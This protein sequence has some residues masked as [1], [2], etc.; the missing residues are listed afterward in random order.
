MAMRRTPCTGRAGAGAGA[1]KA[2]AEA[3]MQASAARW[4]T[5]DRILEVLA[6][7]ARNGRM[8]SVQHACRAPVSWP[9]ALRPPSAAPRWVSSL[10]KAPFVCAIFFLECEEKQN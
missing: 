6:A 2:S 9:V 4:G 3:A 8:V 1:R 10:G 7:R 5:H